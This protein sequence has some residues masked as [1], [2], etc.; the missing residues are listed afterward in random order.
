MAEQGIAREALRRRFT[1]R[2]PASPRASQPSEAPT[3]GQHRPTGRASRR[4]RARPTPS[5]RPAMQRGGQRRQRH[6]VVEHRVEGMVQ[7]A[8]LGAPGGRARHRPGARPARP[9][10]RRADRGAVRRRRRRAGRFLGRRPSFHSLQAGVGGRARAGR[11][12]EQRAHA[13]ARARQAR[14]H[15]TGGMPSTRAVSA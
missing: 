15:G 14:H 1:R 7:R 11:R 8:R 3:A 12:A 13:L 4:G 5:R 2:G 9:R 6:G 10:S